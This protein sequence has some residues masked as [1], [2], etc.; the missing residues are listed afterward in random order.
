MR[1]F[2]S[3]LK[4]PISDICNKDVFGKVEALTY[5][6]EF[7]KRGLPLTH[8]LITFCENDKVVGPADIDKIVDLSIMMY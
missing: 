5:T 6:I 3:N 2:K 4:E 7:Q 1:I 8:I